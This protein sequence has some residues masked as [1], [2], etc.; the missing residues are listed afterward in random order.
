MRKRSLPGLN[1]ECVWVDSTVV[2]GPWNCICMM[3]TLERFTGR[4]SRGQGNQA[5][6][7]RFAWARVPNASEIF[8][9]G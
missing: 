9:A 6:Q 4:Q 5:L 1:P 8:I 2:A 7:E 3:S